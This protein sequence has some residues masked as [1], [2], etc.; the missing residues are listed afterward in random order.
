MWWIER[1]IAH[2]LVGGEFEIRYM[3]RPTDRLTLDIRG[4]WREEMQQRIIDDPDRDRFDFY[5]RFT[6]GFNIKKL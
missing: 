5:I 3:W 4:R 6:W 1:T 2:L